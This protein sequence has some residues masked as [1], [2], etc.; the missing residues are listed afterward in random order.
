MNVTACVA[1]GFPEGA[2][3]GE[4]ELT[5]PGSGDGADGEGAI[6]IHG[7]GCEALSSDAWS[8]AMENDYASEPMGLPFS[9]T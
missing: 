4:T 3:E 1:F 5:T 8:I 7:R 2:D 9:Q 6:D